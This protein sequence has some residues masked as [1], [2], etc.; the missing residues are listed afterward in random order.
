MEIENIQLTNFLSHSYTQLDLKDRGLVLLEGINGSGKSSLFDAISWGLYNITPRGVRADRVIRIGQE[1][2]NVTLQILSK[3]RSIKVSRSRGI[4]VKLQLWIDDQEVGKGKDTQPLLESLIGV[5]YKTF[6]MIAMYPQR[7]NGF[8][9][10]SDS[11]NKGIFSAILDFSKFQTAED[12]AKDFLKDQVK[13]LLKVENQILNIIDKIKDC[14]ERIHNL[15]E[16]QISWEK[17]RTE[18]IVTLNERLLTLIPPTEQ[19]DNLDHDIKILTE[20]LHSLNEDNTKLLVTKANEAITK[21]EIEMSRLNTEIRTH[22][23]SMIE[24]VEVIDDVVE[25]HTRCPRCG[26]LLMDLDAVKKFRDSWIESIN[27]GKRKNQNLTQLIDEACNQKIKVTSRIY[28]LKEGYRDVIQR[29]DEI[30][31]LKGKLRGYEMSRQRIHSECELVQLK[32]QQTLK[33]ISDTENSKCPLDGQILREEELLEKYSQD[34]VYLNKQISEQE[35]EI[36]Y[37]EFLS[38]AFGKKGIQSFLLDSCIP[39]LNQQTNLYM[40]RLTNGLATINLSNIK[41]LSSGDLSENLYAEVIYSDGGNSQ[42]SCISGGESNKANIAI[43]LGLGDLAELRAS[44]PLGFRFFD[45]PFESLDREGCRQ[46]YQLLSEEILPKVGTIFLTTHNENLKELFPSRI[47]VIKE[48]G[49][50]RVL[51]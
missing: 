23:N 9:S 24:V 40:D 8:L 38:K 7:T 36:K 46:L 1:T 35:H 29:S 48:D 30:Q 28:D 16:A 21:Y 20:K 41:E 12:R 2:C 32:R 49:I 26:Q 33:E 34:L 5:D 47:Q 17:A 43:M 25:E 4:S 44:I 14:K 11:D 3:G 45:E 18:A 22:H 39:Y 13:E 37:V 50:S 51:E 31:I 19:V 15:D 27:E 10:G 6:H 42:K